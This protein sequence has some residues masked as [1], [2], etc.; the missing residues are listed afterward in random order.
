MAAPGAGAQMLTSL[1]KFWD[2]GIE[3]LAFPGSVLSHTGGQR[4]LNPYLVIYVDKR[5]IPDH[6]DIYD[7]R[8]RDFL[9]YFMLLSTEGKAP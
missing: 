2:Q 8:L 6:N 5:I 9:R 7:P 4:L 3:E 1:G